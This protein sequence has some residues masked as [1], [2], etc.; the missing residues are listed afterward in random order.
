MTVVVVVSLVHRKI[1]HDYVACVPFAE[2]GACARRAY[3]PGFHG[4]RP[5]G[6][7]WEMEDIIHHH[8]IS[9]YILLL[10]TCVFA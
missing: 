3:P 7:P 8:L 6:R 9:N 5:L 10:F 2:G 4:G 1:R